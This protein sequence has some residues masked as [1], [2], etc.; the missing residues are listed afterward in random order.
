APIPPEFGVPAAQ[1]A[2]PAFSAL[3]A[4]RRA[5]LRIRSSALRNGI[6]AALTRPIRDRPLAAALLCR[7]FHA[8]G[9]IGPTLALELSPAVTA[10]DEPTN[11]PHAHQGARQ[12]T[13]I[14]T[15]DDS[16]A[17]ESE[18]M[19]VLAFGALAG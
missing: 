19:E 17:N 3:C 9:A 10:I 18:W 11:W 12:I 7:Q 2:A 5:V 1:V 6:G 16:P 14:A 15:G 13:G 8:R 4:P